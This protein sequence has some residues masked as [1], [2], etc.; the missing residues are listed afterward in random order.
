[1]LIIKRLYI[2]LIVIIFLFF[3][4]QCG[5]NKNKYNSAQESTTQTEG[6]DNTQADLTKRQSN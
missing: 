3:A 1:M 2:I 4:Y 6:S 5:E